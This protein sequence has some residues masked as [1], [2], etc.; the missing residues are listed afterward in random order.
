MANQSDSWSNRSVEKWCTPWTKTVYF[1]GHIIPACALFIFG[2]TFNP[3]ALYYFAT[4][5]NFRRSAYSYYF[6]TIAVVDLARLILWFL[7]QLLD[8]HIFRLQFHPFECPTQVFAESV[9][10]S[11]S[12]WLTVSLTV[13]RCLAIYRPLQTVT[14]I[15]GKRAVTVIISVIV[16]SCFVNALFLLPGFYDQR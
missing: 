3:I 5:K 16:L 4:S 6:S 14:D 1:Y 15:R 10:S 12:A 13:E 8:Y 9:A 2:L 7:F 11:I